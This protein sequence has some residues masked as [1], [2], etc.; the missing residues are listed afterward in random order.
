M[1]P[2]LVAALSTKDSLEL[3]RK[4]DP[5]KRVKEEIVS[6][7]GLDLGQFVATE[8]GNL[9][10]DV[11][12]LKSALLLAQEH[13]KRKGIDAEELWTR[14]LAGAWPQTRRRSLGPQPRSALALR[15]DPAQC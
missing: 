6:D 5:D 3:L 9:P 12:L 14:S 15:R 1:Q 4:G 10:L 7:P 8:L 11:A 2:T 13:A